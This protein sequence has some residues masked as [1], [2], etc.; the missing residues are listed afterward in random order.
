MTWSSN[1][2]TVDEL[3]AR[4]AAISRRL[5]AEREDELR[6]ATADGKVCEYC[7][8]KY[9][10]PTDISGLGWIQSKYCSR[11]CKKLADAENP[12]G[13]RP[14][15]VCAVCG[16]TYAKRYGESERCWERS[17]Y[18]SRRCSQKALND[19]ERRAAA[20]LAAEPVT[21]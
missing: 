2:M 13:D 19:P 12:G 1:G 15:K 21:A 9:T 17:K 14:T 10:R 7:H 18:C 5:K 6:A 8:M 3:V 20:K 16:E 11:A 4:G